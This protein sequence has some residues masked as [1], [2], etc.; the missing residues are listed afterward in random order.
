MR[1]LLALVGVAAALVLAGSGAGATVTVTITKNGYVPKA[2]TV[3][4]GDTVHFTNSDTAAHQVQFKSTAGVTCTPNPL[5]LQPS[6]SGNCTFATAGKYSY[7]DPNV[8]GG[9]FQGTVTVNATAGA[10]S[11][12]S[13][14]QVV[15]FGGRTTVSGKLASGQTGQTVQ[16]L[17]QQCGANAAKAVGSATTTTGGAFTLSVQPL[18][19]TV[20]TAKLKNATS[21]TT[22]VQVRPR[23]RLGKVAAHR[24]S[25]RVFANASLA[26]KYVSFQ[27]YSAK[28]GHWVR[29]RTV[30][31]GASTLGVAPTVISTARFRSG[32]RAGLRVRAAIP[33]A[34]AGACYLGGISNTI[35]S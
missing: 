12:Q 3:A 6:Q 33:A 11:V 19:N 20:Y 34:Q 14:P 28:L 29:V 23:L 21:N 7:S 15:V 30:T 31:L 35:R 25:V 9:A 22:S 2:T 32:V 24:Y 8:K 5:V 4:A 17:A 10:L 1:G 16:V 13:A 26:G 27:R 18:Q